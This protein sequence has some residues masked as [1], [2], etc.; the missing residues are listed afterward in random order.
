MQG[1]AALKFDNLIRFAMPFYEFFP[2]FF[3]PVTLA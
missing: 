1:P 2:F 3:L